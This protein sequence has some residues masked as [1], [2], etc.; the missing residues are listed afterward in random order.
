MAKGKGQGR[1][2]E[3]ETDADDDFSYEAFKEHCERVPDYVEALRKNFAAFAP[4]IEEATTYLTWYA[5]NRFN[6]YRV[7]KRLDRLPDIKERLEF[8]YVI[9]AEFKQFSS[10][11]IELPHLREEITSKKFAR[12]CESEVQ[13]LERL[14]DLEQSSRGQ[15]DSQ[16]VTEAG[17][18]NPEFTTKRQV[19]ALYYMLKQLGVKHIDKTVQ[20]RFIEF[21]TGKNNKSI[22]DSVRE[23]DD[24]IFIKGGEDARYVREW[25]EKL[26]LTEIVNELDAMLGKTEKI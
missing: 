20:A 17:M 11:P 1:K 26:G 5:N 2:K 7:R 18:R 21:L 14:L 25:F 15:S 9:T 23:V 8:L 3:L 13:K 22:Y 4:R 19:L 16:S 10:N 6:F 12:D 24:I